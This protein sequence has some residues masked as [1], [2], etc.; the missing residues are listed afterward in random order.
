MIFLILKMFV[1]LLLALLAGAGA[2][3][4]LRHLA[5]ARQEEDMQR[6]LADAR[7]RVPQF[8]SLIRSRDEQISRLKDDLKEKDARING[9]VVELRDADN[10]LKEKTRELKTLSAQHETIA[11]LSAAEKSSASADVLADGGVLAGGEMLDFGESSADSVQDAAQNDAV[12]RLERELSSA[13]SQAAD[14]MA[15]AAAAEA[16]VITLKAQLARA[17][18]APAAAASASH[19]EAVAD[20][21]R[22]LAQKTMDYERLA[23]DLEV[24]QRRVVELERERELQN[25]SLRVLHQQLELEREKRQ[26]VVSG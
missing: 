21:E 13:R 3:W 10:T 16:E 11:D 26:R 6:T 5:A 24:E 25:K 7:A 12:K 18:A 8:E 20:L 15:E 2:G 19:A 17:G 23:R 9:L 4:I 22:R 1:Y 14:A